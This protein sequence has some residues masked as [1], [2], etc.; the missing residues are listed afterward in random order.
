MKLTDII[1]RYPSYY[2][3]N[4]GICRVRMFVNK[5]QEV[6]VILSQIPDDSILISIQSTANLIEKSLIENGYVPPFAQ[7]IEHHEKVGD[8]GD[9]FELRIFIEN[10][11]PSWKCLS[12]KEVIEMIDSSPNE[13]DNSA[14]DDERL[15]NDI[16]RL[17]TEINPFA[18]LPFPEDNE[19][20]KRRIEIEEGKIS[21]NQI[22]SLIKQNSNE[23]EIQKLLKTDLSIFAEV[24]ARPQD[25]YICFSEFPINNGFVDFVI[26][27]GLSRM[28]VILIE[29]KGANFNLFLK[30]HYDKFSSKIETA[31]HQ[32]RERTGYITRNFEEFKKTVHWIRKEVEI[33][34]S[35]HNSFIGPR[36]YLEVDE[37]KDI[38]LYNV[39]IGG[40]TINDTDES[41]KRHDFENTN[42]L[43]VKVESWDTFIR[44]LRRK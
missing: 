16:E 28:D 30:S 32:I 42:F 35:I 43:N 17:K 11:N 20:L 29:V 23:N 40:H 44:K 4:D 12:E 41:R 34:K 13:F 31:M 21:K 39:I 25:D 26:F 9:F 5:S 19:V 7:F 6:Y 3:N 24:Y 37:N 38:N 1:Y 10:G 15:L 33:G 8:E 22:K 14:L 18:D 2:E 36:T 27:T